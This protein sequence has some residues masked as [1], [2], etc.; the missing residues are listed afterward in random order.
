M[1]LEMFRNVLRLSCLRVVFIE[2]NCARL[3]QSESRIY[4]KTYTVNTATIVTYEDMVQ[5]GNT[6]EK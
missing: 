6:Q 4:F 1:S 2:Q 3:E 5:S